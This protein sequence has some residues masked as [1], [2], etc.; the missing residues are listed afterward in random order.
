[1]IAELTVRVLVELLKKTMSPEDVVLLGP[2]VSVPGLASVPMV[3]APD[4]VVMRMPP[5]AVTPPAV[6][7]A[8]R[9]RVLPVPMSI[10]L[11]FVSLNLMVLRNVVPPAAIVTLLL[12]ELSTSWLALAPEVIVGAVLV[13]LVAV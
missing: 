8:P 6:A 5:A 2:T 3:S 9:S 1:M 11:A 10:V 12:V 4:V 13:P 7:P